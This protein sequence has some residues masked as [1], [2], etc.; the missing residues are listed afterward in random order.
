MKQNRLTVVALAATL[1][2]GVTIASCG[3]KSSPEASAPAAAADTTTA[4]TKPAA[5]APKE[6][7]FESQLKMLKENRWTTDKDFLLV[8]SPERQAEE[9]KAMSSNEAAE[10][11]KQ[12]DKPDCLWMV[13][14][15]YQAKGRS[16]IFLI[17]REDKY[18]SDV[19][20]GNTFTFLPNH[21]DYMLERDERGLLVDVYHI[22]STA[23]RKTMERNYR[24]YVLQ[25]DYIDQNGR[26]VTFVENNNRVK[27]LFG[28]VVER[29]AFLPDEEG[30]PTQTICIGN[31]EAAYGVSVL[32]TG[33]ELAPGYVEDGVFYAANALPTMLKRRG[34]SP[35]KK[36]ITEEILTKHAAECVVGKEMY[37]DEL[38]KEHLKELI[39]YLSKIEQPSDVV[40][41]NL[42]VLI[43]LP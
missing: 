29:Y 35:I 39:S 11:K 26:R 30:K 28:K 21:P 15:N 42:E 16:V 12:A 17:N 22:D 7:P 40:K 23:D 3:S 20:T 33:L 13:Y 38:D 19:Q 36:L 1:A 5:P 10:F 41:L 8:A 9:M 32:D 43:N 4:A 18:L 27:G 25:G 34:K 2:L 24:H 14:E 31:G 6:D 37:G